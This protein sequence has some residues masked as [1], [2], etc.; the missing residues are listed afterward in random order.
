MRMV[1]SETH[2]LLLPVVASSE[3]MPLAA[4]PLRVVN[5][6]PTTTRDWSGIGTVDHTSPLPPAARGAQGSRDPVDV[7]AL[8]LS[9]P[10]PSAV[11]KAPTWPRDTPST[12]VKWPPT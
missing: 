10:A 5:E 4:T 9:R 1:G 12:A 8:R 6:P 7:T 11:S 3:P 2:R